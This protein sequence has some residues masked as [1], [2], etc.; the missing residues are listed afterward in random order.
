MLLYVGRLAAVVVICLLLIMS[1][2]MKWLAGRF[3]SWAD[4]LWRRVEDTLAA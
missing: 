4:S 3:S 1:I 2:G